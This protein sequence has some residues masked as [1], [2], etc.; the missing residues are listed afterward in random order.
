MRSVG[1]ALRCLLGHLKRPT[2]PMGLKLA[3][4]E[5]SLLV[6]IERVLPFPHFSGD[7]ASPLPLLRTVEANLTLLLSGPRSSGRR[8]MPDRRETEPG[9]WNRILIEVDDLDA[10]VERTRWTTT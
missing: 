4:R 5:Q 2:L 7:I 8:S 3:V 6:L 1:F 9:G 10:E